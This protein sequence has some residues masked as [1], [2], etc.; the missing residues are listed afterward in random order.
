MRKWPLIAGVVVALG[1]LSGVAAYE[2]AAP[3]ED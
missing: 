2:A 1:A 3:R